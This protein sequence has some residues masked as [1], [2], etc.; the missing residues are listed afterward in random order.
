MFSFR[1]LTSPSLKKSTTSNYAKYI[2]LGVWLLLLYLMFVIC[3]HVRFIHSRLEQTPMSVSNRIDKQTVLH[4]YN[5]ILYNN[6][7]EE[8]YIH[9]WQYGLPIK[10]M[11]SICQHWDWPEITEILGL[12]TVATFLSPCVSSSSRVSFPSSVSPTGHGPGDFSN[13]WECQAMPQS[14]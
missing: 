13:C 12:P 9:Q 8:T 2:L 14:N 1:S 3:L 6:G 5:E 4:L 10:D 7:K 11:R